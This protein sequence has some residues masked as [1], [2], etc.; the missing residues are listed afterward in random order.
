MTTTA[1]TSPCCP[2]GS[3]PALQFDYEPK[4]EH[5]ELPG[6]PSRE[7]VCKVYVAGASEKDESWKDKGPA[8]LMLSDIFGP[9][10]GT[11]RKLADEIAAQTGG[12]VLAPDPF[13]GAGGLVPQYA[14]ENNQPGQL[15]FNRFTWNLV[16]TFLWS[17]KSFVRRFP[18][19]TKQR[20]LFKDQLIPFLQS[21]GIEKFALLGFCYGT[22]LALRAC[23]DED[24]VDH[25]TCA[26]HFHPSVE[27]MET[28]FGRKEDVALCKTAQKPQLFH[29]T[30][31][32][33]ANWKPNG[34]A[35]RALEENPNVPEVQFT[36]APNS[37][38]HGFMTRVDVRVEENFKAVK[39]GVDLGVAFLKKY[40]V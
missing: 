25:V 3:L 2:P 6:V 38:S 28:F 35:H 15:G 4:G 10:S 39:E 21:K 24:I 18:W 11:H 27:V 40:N 36:L 17:G 20:F 30:K 19:D 33:S 1:A 37:Q 12:I 26:I 13:E 5:F 31:N 9:F 16:T 23:N 32:E 22:W 29:A 7:S 14:D 34:T 8:L